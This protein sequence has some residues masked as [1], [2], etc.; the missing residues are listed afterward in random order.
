MQSHSRHELA[1][2]SFILQT[3]CI[4]SFTNMCGHVCKTTEQKET[5][6]QLRANADEATEE[7]K[8]QSTGIAV[9]PE[10]RMQV[11]VALQKM[12][13]ESMTNKKAKKSK[14]P[15][16]KQMFSQ[17]DLATEATQCKNERYIIMYILGIV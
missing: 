13:E 7:E 2:G 10:A 16:P 11:S 6:V 9:S 14:M 15:I 17:P 5:H 8:A 3:P 1:E 12:W 4:S